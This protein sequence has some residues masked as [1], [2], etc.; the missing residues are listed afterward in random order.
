MIHFLK[1]IEPSDL[2]SVCR[3]TGVTA[4]F[5]PN[6]E[7]NP[8]IQTQL[9]QKAQA[10]QTSVES[11]TTLATDTAMVSQLSALAVPPRK[12]KQARK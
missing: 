10:N 3:S 4:L 6:A 12:S 7:T 8:R 1:D 2:L 5:I 11:N 9:A